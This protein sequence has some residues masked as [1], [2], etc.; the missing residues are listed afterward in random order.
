LQPIENRQQRLVHLCLASAIEENQIFR[1]NVLPA[2]KLSHVVV[3]RFN[4]RDAA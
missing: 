4:M 3:T 1:V 2:A